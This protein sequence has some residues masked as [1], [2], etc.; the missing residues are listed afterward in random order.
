MPDL[1]LAEVV[2]EIREIRDHC[3][4]NHHNEEADTLTD[5]IML[6]ARVEPAVPTEQ[7]DWRCPNCGWRRGAPPE[8]T[9]Q[10]GAEREALEAALRYAL[11]LYDT[12]QDVVSDI[13]TL[14]LTD[15]HDGTS[16]LDRLTALLRPAATEGE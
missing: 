5:A 14:S 4:D 1:T 6:L 16:P 15:P 9:V 11:Q 2:K 3:R 10:A 13:G 12:A 7:P 8:V